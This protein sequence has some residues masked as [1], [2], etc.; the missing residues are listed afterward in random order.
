[1][2]IAY[3]C[4]LQQSLAV[5]GDLL[6]MARPGLL[7]EVLSAVGEEKTEDTTSPELAEALLWP[8]HFKVTLLH[9]SF[10]LP[11]T[12]KPQRAKEGGSELDGVCE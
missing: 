6:E 9:Q 2:G 8:Q 7:A 3:P 11:L 1:M 10:I 5:R 4:F 12:T